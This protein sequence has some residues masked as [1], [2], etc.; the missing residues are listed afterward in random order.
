MIDALSNRLRLFRPDGK[1]LRNECFEN[2]DV[3]WRAPAAPVLSFVIRSAIRS[4]EKPGTLTGRAKSAGQSSPEFTGEYLLIRTE[5]ERSAYG[6]VR[7][8]F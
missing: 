1:E 5:V 8:N 7:V 2:V 4:E 6:L 3:S